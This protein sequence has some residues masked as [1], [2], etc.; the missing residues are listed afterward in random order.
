MPS[1]SKNLEGIVKDNFNNPVKH[2][3][4]KIENSNFKTLTDE[5]GKYSLDYAAGSFNIHFSKENFVSTTLD[6]N[7]SD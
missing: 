7:I 2:V 6:L 3:L 1:C 5:N 4:V